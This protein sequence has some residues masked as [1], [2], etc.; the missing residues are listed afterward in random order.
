MSDQG[1]V[2]RATGIVKSFGGP[3]AVRGAS[4]EVTAGETVSIIGPNGAGKSTLFGVCAGEHRPDEGAVEFR[5]RTVTRWSATRR[6]RAGMSR[7]FQVASFFGSRTVRENL[8][9]AHT[10]TGG[11][12]LA[13][14]DVRGSAGTC[15]QDVEATLERMGLAT[16]ADTLAENLAQGDRKRLE[17]A[18]AMLQQPR[19]LLLD[20]PTAGM[21]VDDIRRTVDQLRRIKGENPELAVVLT[22]HDMDVVFSVSDRVVLMGQGEVLVE[23]TPAEVE[24]APETR[25][26]YL[27]TV[28]R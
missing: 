11:T 4:F 3:P 6:A 9:V 20:E 12:S 15:R 7:T 24:A 2:L 13:F 27:G 25:E 17:L 1:V 5:G 8:V 14:W 10:A 26:L 18:M 19:L 16:L 28:D 23:G 21:S 22:A